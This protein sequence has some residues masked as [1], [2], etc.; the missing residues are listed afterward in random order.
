MLLAGKPDAPFDLWQRKR[1][2]TP[3]SHC[4]T[5]SS[6]SLLLLLFLPL[7]IFN[8]CPHSRPYVWLPR[9]SLAFNEKPTTIPRFSV[10]S[11]RRFPM[12]T[13][14]WEGCFQPHENQVN[15]GK[16]SGSEKKLV[17]SDQNHESKAEDADRD[18]FPSFM[19]YAV[20]L[21]FSWKHSCTCIA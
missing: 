2:Q 8:P 20:S 4:L 6:K 21:L 18:L 15:I 16:E 10:L 5:S 14:E 17:K 12:N 13:S 11:R 19:S 3:L 9:P 7:L 1:M